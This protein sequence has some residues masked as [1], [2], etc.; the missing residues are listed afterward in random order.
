M[1]LNICDEMKEKNEVLPSEQTVLSSYWQ[2]IT[3][4][5]F[6]SWQTKT[7]VLAPGVTEVDPGIKRL[8]TGKLYKINPNPSGETKPS[9]FAY[10]IG[11]LLNE[12][13]Q[14]QK[15]RKAYSTFNTLTDDT[16]LLADTSPHAKVIKNLLIYYLK[17]LER[18]DQI[19]SHVLR[20]TVQSADLTPIIPEKFIRAILLKILMRLFFASDQLPEDTDEIMK[21]FSTTG[22]KISLSTYAPLAFFD[23]EHRKAKQ[24]YKKFAKELMGD[25]VPFIFERFQ[26]ES[27]DPKHRGEN[28][29]IDLIVQQAKENYPSLAEDKKA[30]TRYLKNLDEQEIIHYL[31][32]MSSF[33]SIL[34]LADKVS[35]VVVRCIE[36]LRPESVSL[37]AQ[38]SMLQA[39]QQEAIM[40][41][42]DK[43][44]EGTPLSRK[45]L[46][47]LRTL[48]SY[49]HEGLKSIATTNMIGR[50]NE[51]PVRLKNKKTGEEVEISAQSTLLFD[52]GRAAEKEEGVFFSSNFS[53]PTH[54]RKCPGFQVAAQI[55]KAITGELIFGP[56]HLVFDSTNACYLTSRESQQNNDYE[57]KGCT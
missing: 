7:R 22:F 2:R 24:Q 25:Q 19:T 44:K 53:V 32:D 17:D 35:A 15:G 42:P 8:L 57:Q 9:D 26:S 37:Q 31:D 45:E 20:E 1:L 10:D 43:V 50:Y 54:T 51:N 18:I 39:I 13:D 34:M 33:P 11:P 46:R 6:G 41:F 4:Y 47:K 14:Q 49:Y 12:L 56:K 16:H 52:L 28:L 3:G 30:L 21:L 55:F 29:F 5:V 23:S 36:K 38:L 48:D 40:K 27:F